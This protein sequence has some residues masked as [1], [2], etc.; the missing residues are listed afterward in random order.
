AEEIVQDTFER[1][2]RRP[3]ARTDEPWRPWLARVAVNLSIDRLR[4]RRRRRAAAD[5]WLPA[6][7][8]T[9]DARRATEWIASASGADATA[10]A[11]AVSEGP[12]VRYE[13]LESVTF[14]F[15]LAVEALTPRQRAILILRDVFDYPTSEIAAL[16]GISESNVRVV[17]HRAR[18]VMR[19]YN[20][21]PCRPDDGLEERTRRVLESFMRCLAE[22]DV[23]GLAELLADNV[24]TVTDPDGTYTAVK[25]PLSGRHAVSRLYLSVAK[26]RMK[27]ANFDICV[28]NGL[29]VVVVNFAESERQQ[30]PCALIHCELDSE[31]LIREI[32]TVLGPRKLADILGK[33]A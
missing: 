12:E 22:Q 23:D 19:S 10:M 11:S 5:L 13:L 4:R 31:G 29:P 27:V 7:L 30:A 15:L 2:A 25:R 9:S 3:P 16:L 28:A 17:L 14:A 33:T 6:P 24:R 20:G 26:R 8:A 1:A 32:D 18:T 21:A